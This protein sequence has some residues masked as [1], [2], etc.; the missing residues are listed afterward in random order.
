MIKKILSSLILI[1]VVITFT[2]SVYAQ[3]SQKDIVLPKEETI[4]RDYFATGN[5]VTVSGTVN[6]DAYAAGGNVL[7]EGNINGDILAAGGNV[8]IRGNIAEDVRVAGGQVIISGPVGGNITVTGGNLTIT[9]SARISGSL[10][11]ASGSVNIYAPTGKEANIAAGNLVISNTINGDLTAATGAMTLTSN[12]R[13]AGNLN[14]WSSNKANIQ[15]GANVTGQVIQNQPAQPQLDETKA[16]AFLAG[17]KL[18]FKLI[19]L[20]SYLILGLL[21]IRFLPIDTQHIAQNIYQNPLKNFGIGLLIL[22]LFPILFITLFITGIGIPIAFLLFAVLFILCFFAPVVAAIAIGQKVFD[23]ANRRNVSLYW[24]LVLGLA[25][26]G[27]LTLVPVIGG[28]VSFIVL[29]LGI[30]AILTERKNMYQ[31]MRSRKMV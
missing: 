21:L 28:L 16:T 27:I 6:G 9:D 4:N 19:M 7:I 29:A 30:G 17:A 14:Y 22:I 10:V 11:A 26:Y 5:N 25:I 12:A 3:D 23:L 8:T 1:L 2:S 13:V 24:A 20:T 15:P 31:T 18:L